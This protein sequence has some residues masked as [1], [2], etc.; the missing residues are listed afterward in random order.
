MIKRVPQNKRYFRE[1]APYV[2]QSLKKE[3][4]LALKDA[5]SR[6]P[7][8]ADLCTRREQKI[9]GILDKISED[10]PKEVWQRG[11]P[12]EMTPGV[13]EAIKS[14]TWTFLTFEDRP[15]FLT[16]DNPV[17]WFGGIG[18]GGRPES[19]ISFPISSHMILWLSWKKDVSEGY[20]Q[21]TEAI[22]KEMNRR[23]A[24]NATRYLYHALDEAWILPFVLK[25]KW[26]V[27][28]LS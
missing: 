10:P 18:I 7:E 22:V 11:I 17:F 2:A 21:A 27:H 8:K 20:Y 26:Q 23:T 19:E 15:A 5:A 14:M 6:N 12:P 1:H 25:G 9:L 3:L 4:C 28:L 24:L 16:C 13:L